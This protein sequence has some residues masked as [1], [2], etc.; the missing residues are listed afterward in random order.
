[1]ERAP[2][3]KQSDPYGAGQ[4]WL[5]DRCSEG[6][7]IPSLIDTM[8]KAPIKTGLFYT[9]VNQISHRALPSLQETVAASFIIQ[10]HVKQDLQHFRWLHC[11][12]IC[13]RAC[14]RRIS[15]GIAVPNPR[16]QWSKVLP[17]GPATLVSA[18]HPP[19]SEGTATR[20]G[21]SNLADDAAMGDRVGKKSTMERGCG[22]LY[23]L[24]G[25]E[26]MQGRPYDG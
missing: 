21:C 15:G 18:H 5:K 20:S 14:C 12:Q 8:P 9:I 19:E 3:V 16:L 6:G 25:K 23:I 17:L 26:V 13:Q 22:L 11:R 10:H 2:R 4:N 1:M 24:A 7:G